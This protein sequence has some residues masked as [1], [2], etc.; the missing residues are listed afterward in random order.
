MQFNSLNAIYITAK[1]QK[2]YAP[3]KPFSKIGC[4]IKKE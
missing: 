4:N 2:K 1:Y 3:A